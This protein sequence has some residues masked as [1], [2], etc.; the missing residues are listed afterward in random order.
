MA[1]D[2][3]LYDFRKHDAVNLTRNEASD[4]QPMWHNAM[5]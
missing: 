5:L 2:I 3:W 1:P 4:S